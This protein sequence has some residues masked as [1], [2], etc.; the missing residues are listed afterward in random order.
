MSGSFSSQ[1]QAAR[2]ADFRDIRLH[3]VRI[4]KDRSDAYWLYVEQAAATTL[5]T[6]YR[7]RI[8][9]VSH[10]AGDL[11]ESRVFELPEPLR[12]AGAWQQ[13]DRLAGLTEKD[14]EDRQGCAILLRALPDQSFAGSTLGRLCVS[15]H[16]GST[17]ATSEVTIFRERLV[18]WD[19]GWDAAGKQVW[20]AE[21]GGYEFG[22]LESYPL[23]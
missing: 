19:R 10:V 11:Y 12:F 18:S 14:I 8:Y 9:R 15:T 21:K 5:D 4:W 23:E 20:G 3:M 17:Y 6:P 13:P 22:K 1:E 2:D 16:R 7:Q